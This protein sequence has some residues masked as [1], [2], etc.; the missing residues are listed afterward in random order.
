[1]L[2]G[3]LNAAVSCPCM[4]TLLGTRLACSTRSSTLRR[5]GPP[6]DA[7]PRTRPATTP[8]PHTAP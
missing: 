1:M 7:Y 3:A 4:V 6:V 5:L 2:E 8:D